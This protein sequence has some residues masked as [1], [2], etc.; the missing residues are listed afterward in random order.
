METNFT[1][2]AW[3][4]EISAALGQL[5]PVDPPPGTIEAA[6]DHR[7]KYAGRVMASLACLAVIALS[8]AVMTGAVTHSKVSPDVNS[9]AEKHRAVEAG[10]LPGLSDSRAENPV[11]T[12]VEMP[13]GFERTADV[14]G[15]DLRQAV[16]GRGDESVSVF[17]QPGRVQ[18]RSLG[19]DGQTVINGTEVWIDDDR[20]VAVV[21]TSDGIVSIVGMSR[22]E[23][24]LVLESL[25]TGSDSPLARVQD[26]IA[27]LSGQLGFPNLD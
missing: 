22:A 14:A 24:E 17:V 11:Q 23:V 12:P 19:G 8:A 18:W 20:Q 15:D 21:Q 10:V 6:L 27:E 2:E 26:L 4:L 9:L 5:G 3:E 13:E 16:Y 7:P 25:E 1:E